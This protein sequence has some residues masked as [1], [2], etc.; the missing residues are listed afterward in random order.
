MDQDWTKWV[1][2]VE[3][4]AEIALTLKAFLKQVLLSLF[5]KAHTVLPLLLVLILQKKT[6]SITLEEI[7]WVIA[8]HS[9]I[10]QSISKSFSSKIFP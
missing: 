6:A 7:K 3:A 4:I 9:T 2:H 5:L 8:H 1:I 10:I